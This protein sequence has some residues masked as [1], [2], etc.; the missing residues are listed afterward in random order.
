MGMGGFR[1][2]DIWILECWDVLRVTLNI[3]QKYKELGYR[4]EE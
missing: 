1:Y 2:L 3:E 4:T